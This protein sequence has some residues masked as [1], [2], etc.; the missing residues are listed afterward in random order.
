MSYIYMA[1][2]FPLS[3][4]C[5]WHWREALAELPWQTPLLLLLLALLICYLLLI[6]YCVLW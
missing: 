5:D 1:M 2:F 4:H 3:I 6:H